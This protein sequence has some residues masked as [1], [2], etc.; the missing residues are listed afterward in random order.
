MD[1]DGQMID[2][3]QQDDVVF[4]EVVIAMKAERLMLVT[5]A[6]AERTSLSV[7]SVDGWASWS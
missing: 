6:V 5:E 4:A 7:T 3:P 1:P 2:K